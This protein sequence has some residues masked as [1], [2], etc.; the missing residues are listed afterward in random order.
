MDARASFV[1]ELPILIALRGTLGKTVQLAYLC[2]LNMLVYQRDSD[3]RF[4]FPGIFIRRFYG[5]HIT[6]NVN[7]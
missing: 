2:I 7:T 5:E 1:C 4:I 3:F 6:L